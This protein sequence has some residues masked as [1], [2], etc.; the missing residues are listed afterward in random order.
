MAIKIQGTTVIDDSG[1]FYVGK[2]TT[3]QRPA[4]PVQGAIW[5]NTEINSFEGYN[6][7]VWTAV[8]GADEFART[9]AL[10]AL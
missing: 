4:S 6:G 2:G 8:G 7:T 1:V 10:L 9:I 5:Y 3:A